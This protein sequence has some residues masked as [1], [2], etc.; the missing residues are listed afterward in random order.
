MNHLGGFFLSGMLCLSGAA[1]SQVALSPGAD[2]RMMAFNIWGDY[3]KNP[4][5]ER[6]LAIADVILRYQPDVVALQEVT[7]N[8]WSSRLF[9]ALAA[10]YAPVSG[11]TDGKT[12]FTPLLYKKERFALVAAGW[13]LFHEKLDRSKGVTWAVLQDRQQDKRFAAFSTHYWWQG[14]PESNYIRTVN[15]DMLLKRLDALRSQYGCHVFGGG[16]FNCWVG[17]D[18]LEKLR[19]NG[20]VSA[21]DIADIA[22]PE[23]SHHGDPRRGDDGKYHGTPKPEKNEKRYSIDHLLVAPEQVHVHRLHVVLDQDA[24][25]ASDHS[26]IFMDISLK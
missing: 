5:E 1:F 20:Y 8:W 19:Q 26:P 9:S 10:G 11:Q 18:P 17:S 25:D 3:F 24:L 16:D 21:Q 15:S 14:T 2:L 13:D 4:V 22:S 7:A 23:S 6:D 12:N